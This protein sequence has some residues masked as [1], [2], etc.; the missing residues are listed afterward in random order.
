MF[1]CCKTSSHLERARAVV[2]GIL[3][4][5]PSLYRK[6]FLLGNKGSGS[7]SLDTISKGNPPIRLFTTQAGLGRGG[8]FWQGRVGL[9]PREAVQWGPRQWERYLPW[10]LR[11]PRISQTADRTGRVRGGSISRSDLL[12][13]RSC[14]CASSLVLGSA[15][16][17]GMT[18]TSPQILLTGGG[19]GSD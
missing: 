11:P 14:I 2:W 4:P 16:G 9:P 7:K 19:H 5:S 8:L 13:P 12:A 18:R 17:A 1:S 3:S 10:A 6:L 15:V